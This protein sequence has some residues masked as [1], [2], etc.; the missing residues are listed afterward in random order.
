MYA[1]NCQLAVTVRQGA[2][3]GVGN[4]LAVRSCQLTMFCAAKV[5]HRRPLPRESG[6]QSKTQ[7]NPFE[8]D[9]RPTTALQTLLWR[10]PARWLCPPLL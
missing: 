4:R 2:G 1:G 3:I 7:S 6:R 10:Q 5:G 9:S 8:T